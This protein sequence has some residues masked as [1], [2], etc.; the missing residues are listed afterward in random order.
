MK[1]STGKV[2]W[3]DQTQDMFLKSLIPDEMHFE[4]LTGR[5]VPFGEAACLA[6]SI[7]KYVPILSI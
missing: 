6:Q 1:P 2:L 7:L 5:G 3:A 4:T